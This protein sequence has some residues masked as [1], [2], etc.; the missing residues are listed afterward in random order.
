[1]LNIH[2]DLTALF[3][4]ASTQF[5]DKSF[6]WFKYFPFLTNVEI[7]YKKKGGYS[8]KGRTTVCGTVSSLFKSEY[9]PY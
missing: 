3:I 4:Y 2:Y 6:K 8:S 5:N 1:M 7:T 9:P